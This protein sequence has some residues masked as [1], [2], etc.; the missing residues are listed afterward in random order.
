[1]PHRRC[2]HDPAEFADIHSELLNVRVFIGGTDI[3]V[4]YGSG[5]IDARRDLDHQSY[6]F[7]MTA[8]NDVHLLNDDMYHRPHRDIIGFGQ[9]AMIITNYREFVT[10][11]HK[12]VGASGHLLAHP[13]LNG[14][15]VGLV[16]YV[17]FKT[18]QGYLGPLRKSNEYA[19]Q[20]EWRMILIDRQ[21][22]MDAPDHRF[23]NIGDLSDIATYVETEYLLRVGFHGRKW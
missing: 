17:D 16:E 3:E 13:D 18:H 15:F 9:H 5:M 22:N 23:L 7:C 8:V 14:E 1:M 6:I 10:R 4:G 2:R 21:A 11:I 12:A 19:F 20:D